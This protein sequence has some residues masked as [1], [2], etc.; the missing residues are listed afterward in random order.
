M[1]I[2]VLTSSRSDYSI[3]LP[4]LERIRNDSFFELS[5]IAF[6]THL[7][8]KHG[9]TLNQI[10][11]DGFEVAIKVETLPD[12]DTPEAICNAMA[13][14]IANF[15]KVWKAHNFDLV[16][17]LGD[18]FEMF[19]AC[20][21][22]IPF[23]VQLAH[24]SGGEQTLGSIDNYFR[25]AISLF[26]KYHFTSTN[27][28]KERVIELKGNME[29]VYNVGALNF[30]NLKNLSLLTI[31][32]FNQ[33]YKID[34]SKPSIL[35]TFH[36]ETVEFKNN[37]RH[38]KE[39]IAALGAVTNYQLIITMPNA[40]T[41][42]NLIREK[43]IKFIN[44]HSNIVG[45][46]SFGTL[47]YLSCMKHCTFMLGNSSSGFVEAAF[48]PKFVINIGARQLGRILTDNIKNCSINRTEILNA[49]DSFNTV[50]LPSRID[51]YGAGDASRKIL[52][53]IK[54]QND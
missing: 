50:K 2:G 4:L 29:N 18:R 54:Q 40:D 11:D 26:S 8:E 38:I 14:T 28:Y 43:L 32:E 33:Q 52:N 34:M 6:G 37:N 47:G 53:I 27:K 45:I 31:E 49:I 46:E 35:V 44:N 42:G 1:K 36:P 19:S 48:F 51:I 30:D 17:C 5:I 24:I 22:T 12:D 23:N 10:L 21:S 7:S 3:Y 39:L 20:A 25:H 15:S 16:F 41:Q 9:A 13:K